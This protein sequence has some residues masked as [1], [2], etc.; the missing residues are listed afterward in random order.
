MWMSRTTGHVSIRIQDTPSYEK[1]REFPGFFYAF[2]CRYGR[3]VSPCAEEL[4]IEEE[5]HYVAVLDDVVLAF[6]SELSCGS[7]GGF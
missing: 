2:E 5:V 7:A 4:Y 1:S 3:W 6:D